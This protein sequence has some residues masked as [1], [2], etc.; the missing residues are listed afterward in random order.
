MNYANGRFPLNGFKLIAKGN[1]GDGYWEHRITPGTL[2]KWERLKTIAFNRT[3]RF[4]ALSTGWSAYRPYEAQV[5]YRKIYGNGAATPG[6]SSHGML[7]EGRICLALDV[8]NWSWVYGGDREQW[9]ADCRAAGFTPGLIHPSR[10]NNY[11]DEPWH[12]I[13]FT[14]WATP[15]APTNIQ[16]EDMGFYCSPDGNKTVYHWSAAKQRLTKLTAA[17]SAVII[18]GQSITEL[19]IKKVGAGWLGQALRLA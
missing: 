3:R 1:D 14:P 18:G 2:H 10:G 7:W 12:I 4:L 15:P 9:F 5:A 19:K 8:G 16:E 17:E 13:D 6:T 11:P